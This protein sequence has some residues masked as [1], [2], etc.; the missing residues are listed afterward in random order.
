M[1]QN[2]NQNETSNTNAPLGNFNFINNNNNNINN[3]S[4]QQRLSQGGVG[5]LNPMAQ[6]GVMNGMLGNTSNT[7]MANAQAGA[8]ANNMNNMNAMN[9]MNGMMNNMNPANGNGGFNAQ[10]SIQSNMNQNALNT[11]PNL[12]N[13]SDFMRLQQQLQQQQ[14]QQLQQQQLQ[15]LQQQQLQQQLQQQMQQQQLQVGAGMNNA[16]PQNMNLALMAAQN[17]N[18]ANN[19][20]TNNNLLQSLIGRNAQFAGGGGLPVQSQANMMNPNPFLGHLMVNQPQGGIGAMGAAGLV[21]ANNGAAT[22]PSMVGSANNFQLPSPNALFSRDASRRMRGGV[23]EPFPEKLHRLLLEVEAAGRA[24]VISFVANGR[25]FAIHKAD[26]FFK[27]IVPLYFRQSRLSSFKRQLN[28]YGFELINTGPARGGY[29]HEMF[30][31]ERPEL[32]R[33]MRRVAVKVTPSKDGAAKKKNSKAKASDDSDPLDDPSNALSVKV[34]EKDEASTDGAQIGETTEGDV[35][36]AEEQAVAKVT[37]EVSN[38]EITESVSEQPSDPTVIAPEKSNQEIAEDAPKLDPVKV[39]ETQDD[40][41][42]AEE[43]QDKGTD[44]AIES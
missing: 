40:S 17:Q 27:E 14:L 7:N 44:E 36:N 2:T 21:G 32:C 11:N 42:K 12:N 28:L 15:Q 35:G 41:L 30:V 18:Q 19:T 3:M 4:A 34:E 9:N 29:Y 33:R 23:I 20:A 31:K 39:E 10:N 38:E 6:Q 16:N 25:A 26:A 13:A 5:L 22:V 8:I 1:N 24:D 37:T 43:T